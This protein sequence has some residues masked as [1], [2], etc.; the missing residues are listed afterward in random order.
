[1]SWFLGGVKAKVNLVNTGPVEENLDKTTEA[2]KQETTLNGE[3]VKYANSLAS[4]RNKPYK[5]IHMKLNKEG[6]LEVEMQFDVTGVKFSQKKKDIIQR[7][8]RVAEQ[9]KSVFVMS[10]FDITGNP[11]QSDKPAAIYELQK[12]EKP[13]E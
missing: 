9:H 11:T 13:S 2:D 10:D 5:L 7:L 1:M 6:H 3:L 8:Q 12:P 4:G